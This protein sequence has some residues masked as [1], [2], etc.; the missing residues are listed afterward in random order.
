MAF[1]ISP[2]RLCD[3]SFS[4]M[5]NESSVS[6]INVKFSISSSISTDK[7]RNDNLSEKCLGEW[8]VAFFTQFDLLKTETYITTYITNTESNIILKCPKPKLSPSS[9][10]L[11]SIPSSK[12][13]SS[14]LS[15]S[16]SP[17]ISPSSMLSP[18][19]SQ[20]SSGFTSSIS[21]E[22]FSPI[23]SGSNK[24]NNG[25]ENFS[26]VGGYFVSLTNINPS[27][28][29]DYL[30]H[31]SHVVSFI[32][33]IFYSITSTLQINPIAI[34]INPNLNILISAYVGLCGIISFCS[35]FNITL[36]MIDST[37]FNISSI[38]TIF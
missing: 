13:P 20:S 26:G 3:V 38:K 9:T 27:S 30:F 23:I 22:K 31:Y 14:M 19:I 4:P 17:S 11:P 34:V 18:S 15:P 32:G 33:A 28:I 36:D 24:L 7:G 37:L 29:L 35:W 25:I 2:R 12:P 6:S 21:Y 16:I 8:M 1:G 10:L 5:P